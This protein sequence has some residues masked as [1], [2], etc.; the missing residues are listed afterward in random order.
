MLLLFVEINY[1]RNQWILLSEVY[2]KKFIIK[3]KRIINRINK[4]IIL[5]NINNSDY[6]R[7]NK[8]PPIFNTFI[9]P[10][11][12]NGISF[13]KTLNLLKAVDLKLNLALI[14]KLY[15]IN[16]EWKVGT[17]EFQDLV[18]PNLKIKTGLP[19]QKVKNTDK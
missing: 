1:I 13:L 5:K 9:S 11:L 2:W 8:L 17:P 6:I 19:D 12:V 18:R 4:I 10:I 15:Q 16:N 3:Q 7:S 14:K